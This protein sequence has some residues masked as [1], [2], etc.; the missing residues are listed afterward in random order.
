MIFLENTRYIFEIYHESTP[1][2][3]FAILKTTVKELLS[4]PKGML[5]RELDTGFKKAGKIVIHS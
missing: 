2:S 1:E 3:P 4:A 5:I